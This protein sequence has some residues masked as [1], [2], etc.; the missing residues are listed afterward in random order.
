MEILIFIFGF[1][2]G[3][4]IQ[5]SNLNKFDTISGVAI[6][7]DFTV[8]KTI[9]VALSVGMIIINLEVIFG[10]ASYEIKPLI[11][12]GI[13]LGGILFG[14]GMAT[15]GYCPGTLPISAGQGAIDAWIGIIGGLTAGLIYTIIYPSIQDILGPNFGKLNVK[16]YIPNT[17]IFILIV[18]IISI[19]FLIFAFWI[20]YKEGKKDYR[21]LISGIG[22]GILN[23][24]FLALI[25]SPIGASATYPYTSSLACSVG[26]HN[27]LNT[28]YFLKIQI[29]GYRELIFLLGALFSGLLFSLL[30][31]EFKPVLI[32]KNWAEYKGTSKLERIFWAF[33]GGFLIIFGARLAGG[34]TSGHIISG[35]MQLA[36][37]AYVFGI[38]VFTT[39][40]ITGYIFYR[41]R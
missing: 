20:N 17:D 2:F 5:Y 31:K 6:L 40:L 37:S 29:P 14:I 39:L 10:V 16:Q 11:L 41:K 23:S 9:L 3:F 33:I 22:I 21:W 38:V 26:F 36:L 12:G 34:C 13:I 19:L 7:K 18:F 27:I 24:I 30:K 4:L 35:G 15:L 8:P 28:P 1:L 32:H 25:G